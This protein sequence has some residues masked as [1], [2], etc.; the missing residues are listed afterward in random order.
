MDLSIWPQ[1]AFTGWHSKAGF[2]TLTVL[3]QKVDTDLEFHG[4]K[5]KVKFQ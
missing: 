3:T 2:P 5:P 4:L 1:L